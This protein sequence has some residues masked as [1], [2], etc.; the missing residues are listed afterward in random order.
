MLKNAS[1][2]ICGIV[3]VAFSLGARAE[4]FIHTSRSSEASLS[5]PAEEES[6]SFAILGDR[7][8]GPDSG[9]LVLERA[10]TH[11][12]RDAER[13]RYVF[14]LARD[15]YWTMIA[16]PLMQATV[17]STWLFVKKR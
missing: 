6:F 8:G 17:W 1:L 3:I 12:P 11:L 9:L 5:K 14:G 2:I 15:R 7:T 16:S 4:S 13:L 10:V